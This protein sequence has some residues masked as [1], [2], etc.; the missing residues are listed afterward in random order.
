MSCAPECDNA[1]TAVGIALQLARGHDEQAQ[2]LAADA[3]LIRDVVWHEVRL[4]YAMS[5]RRG[6]DVESVAIEFEYEAYTTPY[7]AHL[8][9]ANAVLADTDILDGLSDELVT[10]AA[11]PLGSF[12]ISVAVPLAFPE[13]PCAL[14]E[15][16]A[17]DTS[18]PAVSK[19]LGPLIRALP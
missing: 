5:M 16:I 19:L 14:L 6:R 12:L 18:G 4:A 9:L 8:Y 17:A 11:Y 10:C 13:H 7:I 15:R 1:R 2:A 3:P